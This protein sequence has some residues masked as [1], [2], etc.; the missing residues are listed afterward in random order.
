VAPRALVSRIDSCVICASPKAS[1][2]S[3]SDFAWEVAQVKSRRLAI[4]MSILVFRN[5]FR[6]LIS[7]YLNKYVE[8]S[9]YRQA[10]LARCP[11]AQ[12]DSFASFVEELDRHGFRCVDKVHF[13][14]QLARY[15]WRRFDLILNAEDLQP[16][17]AL[18]N[19]LWGTAVTMPFRAAED[20]PKAVRGVEPHS[21]LGD[22][23]DGR[24]EPAP[25]ASLWH[26]PR[27]ELSNLLASGECPPY[28]AFF[29][30]DL[31][32]RCRRIYRLDFAFLDAALRRGIL[33]PGLHGQLT[34][35]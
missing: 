32:A 18:V 7:A 12:L 19:S 28:A 9:K 8:H 27:Q 4:P 21:A 24:P 11:Q 6:R 35:L 5:P 33:D 2:R 23:H 34:T 20:R 16:L 22:G 10:S 17:A 25:G 1:C 26:R 31:M 29:H 30:A 3:V 15:R 13:K 14:P